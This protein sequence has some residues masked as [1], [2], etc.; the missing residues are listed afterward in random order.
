LFVEAKVKI[1]LTDLTP[2]KEKFYLRTLDIVTA[3]G[4]D[5]PWGRAGAQTW[6]LME[7]SE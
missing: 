7:F 1:K 3:D 2:Y 6:D 4:K 5:F